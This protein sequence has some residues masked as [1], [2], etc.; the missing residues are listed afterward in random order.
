MRF[1]YGTVF[2]FAIVVSVILLF[3]YYAFSEVKDKSN[4]PIYM[5]KLGKGIGGHECRISLEDSL[6][7]CS[8]AQATDSVVTVRRYTVKETGEDGKAVDVAR[9]TQGSALVVEVPGVDTLFAKIGSGF[10]YRIDVV[11]GSVTLAEEAE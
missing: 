5:F 3:S 10:I 11:D 2:F 4:Q 1:L 7:Y 6:L 8:S 9:F